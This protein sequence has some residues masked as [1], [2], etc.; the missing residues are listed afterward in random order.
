MDVNG[1]YIKKKL[2]S[3]GKRAS[4]VF[5]CCWYQKFIR[6]TFK[7][8]TFIVNFILKTFLKILKAS[9]FF[10]DFVSAIF[11]YTFYYILFNGDSIIFRFLPASL[12]SFRKRICT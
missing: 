7:N 1:F 2:F 9:F 4:V 8:D 12:S 5:L 10:L 3:R 11:P 6:F